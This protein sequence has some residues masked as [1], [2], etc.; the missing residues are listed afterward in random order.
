MLKSAHPITRVLA[1]LIDYLLV[2]NIAFV[3]FYFALGI[4]GWTSFKFANLVFVLYNILFLYYYDQ[5]TIGK[6]ISKLEVVLSTGKKPEFV[7]VL[8]RETSKLLYLIPYFG[9]GLLFVDIILLILRK[10]L[11][12]DLLSDTILIYY[13]NEVIVEGEEDAYETFSRFTT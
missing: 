7:L 12:H 2:Y 4:D 5:T 3:V 9:L 1:Y 6:K 13:K 10:R 8:V 11:I